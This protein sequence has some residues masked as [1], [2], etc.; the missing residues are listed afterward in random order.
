MK[1]IVAL[2]SLAGI[3]AGSGD[4]PAFAGEG[5]T[6]DPKRIDRLFHEGLN[7]LQN[8]TYEKAEKVFNEILE[9]RPTF[10]VARYCRGLCRLGRYKLPEALE[11]FNAFLE[12]KPKSPKALAQRGRTYLA[13]GNYAKAIEDLS[14]ANRLNPNDKG[15]RWDLDQATL[16]AKGIERVGV[17]K[18]FPNLFL[19]AAHRSG[20]KDPWQISKGRLIPL[21]AGVTRVDRTLRGGPPLRGLLLLFLP[22]VEH[23]LDLDRLSELSEFLPGFQKKGIAVAAISPDPP[24]IL[25]KVK[26]GKDIVYPLYSDT[27]GRGAWQLGILNVRFRELGRPLPTLF[28]LDA[29]GIVRLRQTSLDPRRRPSLEKVLQEIDRIYNK[30]APSDSEDGESSGGKGSDE[31]K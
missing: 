22:S 29:T 15:W 8:K 27:Q 7:L 9:K 6:E 26:E 10:H 1:A 3:L 21:L 16:L 2:L 18:S 31:G 23:P 14:A 28:Y 4:F 11:D 24:E 25:A 30:K 20:E 19:K 13:M 17:G 12:V 5:P